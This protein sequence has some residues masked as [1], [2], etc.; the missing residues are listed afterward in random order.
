MRTP[1]GRS[2][3]AAPAAARRRLGQ[4]FL[5]DAAA[6]RH[7]VT[8]LG[9]ARDAA[10][11]EIGPGRGALT[12]ALLERFERVM[13]VEVDRDLAARLRRRH[14][15]RRLLVVE[16]DVR[17]LD[18]SEV[19]RRL[20]APAAHSLVVVGNLPYSISK[21]VAMRLVVERGRMAEAVLTFQ[22]EVAGRLVARAGSR[23]YGPLSVLAAQAFRI[24]PL[25]D[26]PA[27]AFRP[28]PRVIS[29]VTRWRPR[30][31]GD[32]PPEIE[33]PLRACLAA[34]FARRRQTLLN[35]LRAALQGGDR[36][37]RELL[38]AAGL[39]GGLRPEAISPE[40]YLRLAAVWDAGEAAL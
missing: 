24:E 27:G 32:L 14:D 16:G 33:G 28:R 17:R 37:A 18:W 10:V 19:T 23:A 6:V 29:T 5:V 38:E 36:A 12:A 22:R 40:G 30:P 21:A 31:D 7:I 34:S 20:G 3:R 39:E 26:L 25:F 9:A 8:A 11:L 1:P 35:N 2:R 15:P 13:V 4:H